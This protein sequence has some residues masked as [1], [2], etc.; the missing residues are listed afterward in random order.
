MAVQPMGTSVH[1]LGSQP[2]RMDQKLS[3][4][5]FL[6]MYSNRAYIAACGCRACQNKAS[7]GGVTRMRLIMLIHAHAFGHNLP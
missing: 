2:E 4:G 5:S 3:H 1:V 6:Y 7:Q